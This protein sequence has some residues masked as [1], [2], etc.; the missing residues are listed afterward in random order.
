MARYKFTQ[1][2]FEQ[3]KRFFDQN[4]TYG[5]AEWLNQMIE[6]WFEES[7]TESYSGEVLYNIPF[8]A[9]MGLEFNQPSQLSQKDPASYHARPA[10]GLS[11]EVLHTLEKVHVLEERVKELEGMHTENGDHIPTIISTKEQYEEMKPHMDEKDRV[12]VHTTFDQAMNVL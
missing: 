9:S 2:D 8:N 5:G 7:L 11:E 10:I 1:G 6:T 4:D 3:L 12:L